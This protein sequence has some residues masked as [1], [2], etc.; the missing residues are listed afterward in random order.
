M[1]SHH[2]A[3]KPEQ[4]L[5]RFVSLRYAEPEPND[6][7]SMMVSV[8]KAFSMSP[9]QQEA[10]VTTVTWINGVMLRKQPENA[11]CISW[12]TAG[13]FCAQS[14]ISRSSMVHSN[15]LIGTLYGNTIPC[16]MILTQIKSEDII[17]IS[18]KTLTTVSTKRFK[19][20][21]VASTISQNEHHVQHL[22]QCE[23]KSTNCT[24]RDILF[25]LSLPLI[26]AART[27]RSFSDVKFERCS[28]R[29]PR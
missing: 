2:V 6:L 7:R 4:L 19:N 8:K 25:N 3:K 1:Y 20:I 21:K 27:T 15:V 26:L 23:I 18:S 14:N 22:C 13:R 5:T 12:T 9:S 10:R 16:C 24:F 29:H 28:E 11:I 17:R